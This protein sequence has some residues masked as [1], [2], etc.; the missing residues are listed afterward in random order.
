MGSEKT[1]KKVWVTKYALTRGLYPLELEV[2]EEGYASGGYIGWNIFLGKSDWKE[3]LEEA[4]ADAEKRRTK[5]IA[6]LKKQLAK[7]EAKSF[8]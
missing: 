5:K 3:S 1:V 7:L 2:D 4:M 6:C 8:D